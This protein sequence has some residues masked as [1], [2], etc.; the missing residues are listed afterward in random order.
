MKRNCAASGVGYPSPKRIAFPLDGYLAYRRR[1]GSIP[2]YRLGQALPQPP[3]PELP[4][5]FPNDLMPDPGLYRS[6]PVLSPVFL[7]PTGFDALAMVRRLNFYNLIDAIRTQR[8]AVLGLPACER[9][10]NK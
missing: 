4:I 7:S 1:Y 10:P 6:V 5:G 9:L 3:V 8:Q 2:V